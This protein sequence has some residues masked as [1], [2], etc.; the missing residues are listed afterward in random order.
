M[1]DAINLKNI[2]KTY[3]GLNTELWKRI[4]QSHAKS[5]ILRGQQPQAT[6]VALDGVS[7]S[8]QE[9]QIFG[10]LGVDGSGKST[11]IRL[12]ATLV[13]PD[14]GEAYI[15]GYDVVRQPA[16][17][18]HLINRVSVEASFYRKI[19]ALENLV[20]DARLLGL[21]GSR[22]RQRLEDTLLHLG[23]DTEEI[24]RPLG[25]TCA[26]TQQ[27]VCLA[28]AMISQPRLLLLDE[29]TRNL[30]PHLACRAQE[31]ILEMRDTLGT[32]VLFTTQDI[33]EM[34]TLADSAAVMEKGRLIDQ[35]TSLVQSKL[36]PLSGHPTRLADIFSQLH[37][38]TSLS[39]YE[40]V[41]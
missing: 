33:A 29:P 34:A 26:A 5:S 23:L 10:L 25:E 3:G 2:T 35:H 28:R 15:F 21:T 18:Q 9:G 41:C 37:E 14:A 32:T 27:V 24:Y 40:T 38:L 1:S 31:A 20:E 12:L 36:V 4:S 6:V 19:S 8:V 7:L 30:P 17:V 16:K 22:L 11:L 39:A 13:R